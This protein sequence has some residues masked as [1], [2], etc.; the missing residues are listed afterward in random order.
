MLSYTDGREGR[1]QES[2]RW[3]VELRGQWERDRRMQESQV[4]LLTPSLCGHDNEPPETSRECIDG[5]DI[6]TQNTKCR[7]EFYLINESP[8]LAKLSFPAHALGQLSIIE[9]PLLFFE[10]K[11]ALVYSVTATSQ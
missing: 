4:R 9:S 11:S 10:E 2:G 6:L 3:D 5:G 1:G 7:P 8:A